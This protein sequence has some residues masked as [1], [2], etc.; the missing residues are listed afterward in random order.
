MRR[1]LGLSIAAVALALAV[2]VPVS[3][4]GKPDVTHVVVEG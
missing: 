4:A 2:G 1:F 3:E